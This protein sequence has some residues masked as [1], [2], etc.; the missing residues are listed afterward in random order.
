MRLLI[1]VVLLAGAAE[2]RPWRVEG[3]VAVG[4][5]PVWGP[6][7]GGAYVA[8]WAEYG[9]H[10]GLLAVFADDRFR[11]GPELRLSLLTAQAN[12]I[13]IV[14]PRVL[15][16]V[17]LEGEPVM[18]GRAGL[19]LGLW[20]GAGVAPVP[21]TLANPVD[22]L[23]FDASVFGG[24]RWHFRRVALSV[25]VSPGLTVGGWYHPVFLG[26]VAGRIDF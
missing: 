17:R 19:L 5:V 20:A 9:L 23:T 3:E 26:V 15:A 16:G 6:V 22:V 7:P 21:Y 4:A 24:V 12:G 8:S 14:E 18:W 2:A 11:I 13:D 10:G 25:T 1:L